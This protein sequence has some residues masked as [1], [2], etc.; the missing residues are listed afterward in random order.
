MTAT[1]ASKYGALSEPDGSIRI[2]WD[3][4]AGDFHF[5]WEETGGPVVWPRRKRTALAAC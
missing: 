5:K 2:K 3:T 1:N 4:Q